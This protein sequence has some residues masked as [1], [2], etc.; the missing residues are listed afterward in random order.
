VSKPSGWHRKRKNTAAE[1][2]RNAEYASP[3]YRALRRA[4]AAE[5]Q[6]GRGVCWRPNC[7]RPLPPGSKWHLGHDD[8]DRSII[9]GAECVPCNLSA[10]GRKGARVRNAAQSRKTPRPSGGATQVCL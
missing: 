8:N 7:R 2:A 1:R 10:A 5:V 6:A 3:E 4:V 9:R